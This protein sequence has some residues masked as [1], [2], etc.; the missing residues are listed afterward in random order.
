METLPAGSALAVGRLAIGEKEHFGEVLPVPIFDNSSG[1]IRTNVQIF[2]WN[3][4]VWNDHEVPF[5]ETAPNPDL[6][7]V[8]FAKPG[9]GTLSYVLRSDPVWMGLRTLSLWVAALWAI[10]FTVWSTSRPGTKQVPTQ[11]RPGS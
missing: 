9:A 2:P 8:V 3:R 4:L 5:A 6:L 1:L 7:T 11:R 10:A